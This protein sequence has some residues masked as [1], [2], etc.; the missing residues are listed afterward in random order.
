M[1]HRAFAA[2]TL[3]ALVFLLPAGPA[4]AHG[5]GHVRGTIATVA[6]DHLEIRGADGK[7]ASVRLGPETLYF[8]GT[9]KATA[10]ALKVGLRAVVH[11]GVDKIAVE[12]HLP[13]APKPAGR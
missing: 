12:V 6:A 9:E 5:G 13:A 4:S 1:R 7:A 11:L 2:C 8:Q 3:F 10:A